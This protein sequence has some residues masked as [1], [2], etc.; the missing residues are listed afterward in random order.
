MLYGKYQRSL[1]IS[2]VIFFLLDNK[3][4]IFQLRFLT[5]YQFYIFYIINNTGGIIGAKGNFS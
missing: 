4:L 1:F 5:L 2:V 3:P